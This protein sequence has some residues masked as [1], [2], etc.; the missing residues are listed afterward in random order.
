MSK[1]A[2]VNELHFRHIGIGFEDSDQF[3]RYEKLS[4][5]STTKELLPLARHQ[6]LVVRCYAAWA[7]VDKKY[8]DL[9]ALFREFLDEKEEVIVYSVCL[10]DSDPIS[11][12]LYHRYFNSVETPKKETDP[13]LIRLD[14]II[15]NNFPKADRL[16]IHRAL[17]NRKNL[18]RGVQIRSLG[19][20][21]L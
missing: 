3:A 20:S 7:L 9:D 2:S 8:E 21:F 12:V 1:I 10:K 13:L 6:N 16:L 17:E 4:A 11:S 19:S 18:A 5:S 15:L 14:N